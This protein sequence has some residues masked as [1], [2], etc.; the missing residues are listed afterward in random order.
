LLTTIKE[1]THILYDISSTPIERHIKIKN[2]S[3]PD[4]PNLKEYW[5]NRNTN[6]GKKYWAKGSKYEQ[7]AKKQGWKCAVCGEH[8]FN[9]EN[10]ETHHIV[11]VA[12]GGTDDTEN[13]MHLHSACHKQVHSKTK[14]EGLK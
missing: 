11:P 14:F 10:I 3:S 12:E 4:D 2:N 7:V 1:K 9:G 5:E 6:N 8:L 13:L